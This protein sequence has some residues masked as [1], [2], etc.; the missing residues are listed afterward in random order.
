MLAVLRTVTQCYNPTLI[1]LSTIQGIKIPG[2]SE[3]CL[4]VWGLVSNT[5]SKKDSLYNFI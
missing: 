1:C 4:K 3:V 5:D 2:I